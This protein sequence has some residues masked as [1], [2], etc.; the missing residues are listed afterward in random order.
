MGNIKF[1]SFWDQ[2]GTKVM[3]PNATLPTRADFYRTSF[4]TTI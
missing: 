4:A 1:V 3:L 2:K